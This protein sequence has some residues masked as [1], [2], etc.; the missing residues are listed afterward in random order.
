MTRDCSAVPTR[1]AIG[2]FER[3]GPVSR[4]I[5]DVIPEG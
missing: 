3:Q 5:R 2:T 1:V 4:H